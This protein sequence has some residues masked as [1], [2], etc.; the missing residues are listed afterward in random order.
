[1]IKK[2]FLSLALI[3]VF[4]LPNTTHAQFN[5]ETEYRAYLLELIELLQQ[6][7]ILLQAEKS[8]VRGEVGQPNVENFE[9]FLIDDEDDIAAWYS[10]S[11]PT[12]VVELPNSTHLEYFSRFFEI[13]PNQYDDYFIDL[14]VYEEDGNDFDGF[15]ETVSPFRENT[16]RIGISESNFDF[17]P[18][19]QAVEEL[20][21][22]EFAHIISYEDVPG[23]SL[24]GGASCHEFFDDFGCPPKDS[25]LLDFIE[26]FWSDEDMDAVVENDNPDWLWTNRELRENFVSEYAGTNPAE[27]FAESFTFFVLEEKATGSLLK[28]EKTSYF[29]SFDPMIKLRNEIRSNL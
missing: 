5:N 9:S 10:I 24:S 16:W 11:H 25:Y 13:V 21:V 4:V 27:D 1:M 28:D 12:A 19:S 15:V 6:Q 3:F 17:S 18:S 2:T 8:E 26:E 23:K 7:I 20:F 29:Y 22:H 14:L